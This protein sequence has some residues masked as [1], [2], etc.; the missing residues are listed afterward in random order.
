MNGQN[1]NNNQLNQGNTNTPSGIN[2]SVLGSV[3]PTPNPSSTPVA[4][5]TSGSTVMPAANAQTVAPQPTST[6]SAKPTASQP[7]LNV[8]TPPVT[9]IEEVTPGLNTNQQQVSSTQTSSVMP[10]STTAPSSINP[11]PVA[12]PIPG[13]NG[14][15]YQANSLT[16]NTI[17]VGTPTMGQ[18]NLNSNGFVEP[19]KVENIGVIPPPNNNANNQQK[20]KKGMN[21]TL[22]V[23]LIIVAIAAVAF[24]VYYF[25]SISNKITVKLKDVTIGV[26]DTLSDNIND[27]ATITGKNSVSCTLNTRNVDTQTI[28]T[29]DFTIT[30]GDDK[31]NGKV[32]VSDT[33]APEVTL[34][35]IYKEVNSTATIDE[36]VSSCTDPSECTTTFAN[37]NTLTNYLATAGGPYSIEINASDNAGNSSTYTA[38]LYVTPYPI[39]IFKNCE[40][41]SSEVVGYNATKTI[42]D[43]LPMGSDDTGAL[44]YLGVSQRIYTYVFSN[45]EEYNNVIGNKPQVLTF[46]GKTG[47]TTYN[48]EDLTIKIYTDLSLDTLNNEAGGTFPTGY[49]DM[50]AYYKNLSYTCNNISPAS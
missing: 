12:Q 4:P 17:G 15:P 33:T 36:F 26:G 23:V 21:K 50:D 43:Y 25:L 47:Q 16:G 45:Q 34:N 3:N 49:A 5:V 8:Q 35:T 48:D 19:N 2:A 28:G 46:D 24:G 13:T 41:A 11:T 29:Y 6:P 9:P 18:D 37:E 7:N 39:R 31:F 27:Y 20:K 10:Q 38:Q 14:T 42:S 40:S 30:C 44:I 32:N 22:F 1:P